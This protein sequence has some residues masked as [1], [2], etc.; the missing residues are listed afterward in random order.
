MFDATR[1]VTPTKIAPMANS[2]PETDRLVHGTM[3]GSHQSHRLVDEGRAVRE[4]GS[5]RDTGFG[6]TGC[7]R[8]ARLSGELPTS[9]GTKWK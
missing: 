2:R 6:V 7:R 5:F 9:R 3:L 1:T 8:I 4:G